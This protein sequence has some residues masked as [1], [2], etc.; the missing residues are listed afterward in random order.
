[1]KS[2]STRELEQK[3]QAMCL[4]G[5]LEVRRENNPY[6]KISYKGADGLISSK[7]NV[8]IYTSGTLVCN[9]MGTL[10][11]IL[12][13]TLKEVDASLKVLKIDDAGIGFPLC[14]SLVGVSDGE[15][16][17]TDVVPVRFFQS[18]QFEKETYLKVYA[19]LGLR[20]VMEVFKADTRSHRIEICT[21]HINTFLKELLRQKGF[22]VRVTEIT[23]LL[24]DNLEQLFRD[25]VKEQTQKDL[26]Y[27]PKTL[28]K[29]DLGMAYYRVLNWG[30]RNAPHLLKSGWG[31]MR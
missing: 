12:A 11:Q 3:L 24:Q 10:N 19:E 30:K 27:D 16:V 13:G 31:S 20:I 2:K 23:G 15:R 22:D 7:W 29:S 8:K 9:D 28:K 1:M 18:P 14:G 17:V 6:L 5:A 25:H 21:G 4:Q 26:G